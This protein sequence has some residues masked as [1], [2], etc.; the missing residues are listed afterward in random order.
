MLRLRRRI[1]FVWTNTVR[2]SKEQKGQAYSV[3]CFSAPRSREHMESS[4]S[5]RLALWSDAEARLRPS[6]RPHL[7]ETSIAILADNESKRNLYVF[8]RLSACTH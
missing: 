5:S 7:N 1:P 8:F 2:L 6:T 4:F 3:L